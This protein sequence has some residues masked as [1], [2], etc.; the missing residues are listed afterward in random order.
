MGNRCDLLLVLVQLLAPSLND[1]D[2]HHELKPAA[3]RA[4]NRKWLQSR[5]GSDKDGLFFFKSAAGSEGGGQEVK[6]LH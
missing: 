6:V 1:S 2:Q 3:S 4:T 5:P